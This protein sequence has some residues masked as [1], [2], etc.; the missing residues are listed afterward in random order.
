M[1]RWPWILGVL[2]TFVGW[3]LFTM[4][5]EGPVTAN[6]LS[7]Q[8]TIEEKATIDHDT[9]PTLVKP[10][11]L[12]LKVILKEHYMDGV[13]ATTTQEETIWSMVDFWAR[14]KGWT[15]EDQQLDQVVFKRDV[16]DISPLT[17]QQG[18]FGL[19]KD[20]ELAVFQGEPGNGKVIEAFKPIPIK[21][22]ESR[23]KTELKSGIKIKNF[24]HFEQVL[25]QYSTQDEL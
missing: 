25:K 22:L 23:R 15:V 11:P 18:Y 12:K 3:Q 21:P 24:D 5:Q 20:G 9:V 13:I 14:Y 1:I 19:T 7:Y 2:I 17:K 10:E 6:D 16:K 8:R 4:Q